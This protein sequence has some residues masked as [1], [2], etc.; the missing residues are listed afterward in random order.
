MP[1]RSLASCWCLGAAGLVP[2]LAADLVQ[3]VGR[4]VDD[5]EWV[6]APDRVR[7]PL[8]DRASDRFGHVAGHQLDLFAAFFAQQIEELLDGL[9]VAAGGCPE[10]PAGVVVDDH[11]EVPVAL[12]I[13]E[14]IDPDPL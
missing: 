2:D 6:H 1:L 5:V 3:R 10:Q 13:R 8:A 4:E 11:G 9:A 12:S 14:V 7:A